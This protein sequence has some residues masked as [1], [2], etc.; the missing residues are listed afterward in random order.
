MPL[1]PEIVML[2]MLAAMTPSTRGT[3]KFLLVEAT[4]RASSGFHKPYAMNQLSVAFSPR[5]TP[6]HGPTLRQDYIGS[7]LRSVRSS[8]IATTRR[9]GIVSTFR[10]ETLVRQ[11][12]LALTSVANHTYNAKVQIMMTVDQ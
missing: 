3:W 1:A 5:L 11:G 8:P 10:N 2:T 7:H 12:R 6:A 4:S 9:S